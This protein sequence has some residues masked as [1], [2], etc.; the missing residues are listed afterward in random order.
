MITFAKN[1]YEKINNKKRLASSFENEI[2]RKRVVSEILVVVLFVLLNFIFKSSAMNFDEVRFNSDVIRIHGTIDTNITASEVRRKLDEFIDY[3][4]IFSDSLDKICENFVGRTMLHLFI[5]QM[6]IEKKDKIRLVNNTSAHGSSFSS[7]EF[8][9]TV[10][11]DLYDD[12]GM[13]ING[14]YGSIKDEHLIPIRKTIFSSIF[15]EFCHALHNISQTI[16]FSRGVQLNDF[17]R[18]IFSSINKPNDRDAHSELRVITGYI[19]DGQ[20]DPISC[21]YY[22]LYEY[23]SGHSKEFLPRYGHF[24]YRV[25]DGTIYKGL[26]HRLNAVLM[27]NL[28]NY[29][30]R[31][32]HVM[33]T[34][35]YQI[36]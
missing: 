3:D 19:K 21:Y 13:G 35:L 22:D 28:H 31:I 33:P 24:G 16:H 27:N 2:H 18:M 34:K 6:N 12:S 4:P 29:P 1:T 30:Q 23:L 8:M 32:L 26:P 25:K 5:K 14:Y 9:I 15:H 36:H 11:A 20:F 10:N 17:D 7:S